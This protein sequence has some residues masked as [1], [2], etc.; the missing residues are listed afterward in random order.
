[1]MSSLNFARSFLTSGCADAS[2]GFGPASFFLTG[3]FGAPAGA[4]VGVAPF[5]VAAALVAATRVL[6]SAMRRALRSSGVSS[7]GGAFSVGVAGD[8]PASGESGLLF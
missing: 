2:V 3:A 4:G 7:A 6:A 8:A 1:M 5:V